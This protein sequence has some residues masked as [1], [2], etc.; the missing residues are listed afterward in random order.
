VTRIIVRSQ[1]IKKV[2]KIK[3]R[4]NC[5][6]PWGEGKPGGQAERGGSISQIVV[7]EESSNRDLVAKGGR[8]G[9]SIRG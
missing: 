3:V 7:G 4:G 1:R 9:S 5:E 8:A 2:A 6:R